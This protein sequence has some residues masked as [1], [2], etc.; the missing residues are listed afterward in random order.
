LNDFVQHVRLRT[1]RSS[2][3]RILSGKSQG[4]V[5]GP[6]SILLYTADFQAV[7]EYHSLRPH[8]YADDVQINGSAKPL[9]VPQLQS[10]LLDCIDDVTGC[11]RCN[12]LQLNSAKTEIMWC[13]TSRRQH[14]WPTAAVW[15]GSDFV[16]PSTSVRDLGIFLDSDVSIKTYVRKTICSCFGMLRQLRSVRRPVPVDTFQQLVISL[17]LSRLDYENATLVGLPIQLQQKL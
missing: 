13:S 17:V 10:Q 14:Q 1:H 9:V 4:S 15:V 8:F 3:G 11:M 7:T 6:I 12:R 2:V 5:L 16:A